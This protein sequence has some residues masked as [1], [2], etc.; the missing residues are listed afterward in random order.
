MGYLSGCTTVLDPTHRVPG[1]DASLGDDWVASS[2]CT[3]VDGVANSYW[4]CAGPL[5]SYDRAAAVCNARGAEL[6]AVSSPEEN[7]LLV[8]SSRELGT[9]TNL[10]IGGT[11]DDEHVWRWPD[12]TEFWRGLVAGSA[13]PNVYVNWQSGEPNNI[14]TVTDDPERC[15]A[16]ALFD[17]GW[18]DRACSIELS[19]LCVVR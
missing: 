11:R 15:A 3:Q 14:S 16:L 9:H 8:S 4:I 2:D 1:S 5:A 7:S 10:W 6:A 17:E 18:R 19:Y 13:P 12:G